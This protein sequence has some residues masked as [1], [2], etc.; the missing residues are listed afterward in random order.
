VRA[1]GA[2]HKPFP[3]EST[4]DQWFTESQFESYRMLG[5]YQMAE[6]VRDVRFGDLP[7]LFAAA[8]L[9]AEKD[10]RPKDAAD[11]DQFRRV[12]AVI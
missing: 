6:L 11:D 2:E 1:Y 9:N 5:W 12:A 3:H 7:R 4:L 10:A 8:P